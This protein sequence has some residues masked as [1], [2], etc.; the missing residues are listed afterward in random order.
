ME[1][2][3]GVN[4]PV[5]HKYPAVPAATISK[6]DDESLLHWFTYSV[7]VPVA[8]ARSMRARL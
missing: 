7:M 8:V 3:L 6:N 2:P 5:Y 1:L 4:A